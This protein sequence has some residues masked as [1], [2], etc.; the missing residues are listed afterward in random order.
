MGLGEAD[1]DD[2]AK[3]G[4]TDTVVSAD[5]LADHAPIVAASPAAT[6]HVGQN[7]PRSATADPHFPQKVGTFLSCSLYLDQHEASPG[8]AEP[9]EVEALG[10][11]HGEKLAYPGSRVKETNP[12]LLIN[13]YVLFYQSLTAVSKWVST[14]T[15]RMW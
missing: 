11:R 2:L 7:R 1:E 12:K 4:D 6:P 9:P 15:N 5:V 13:G 10:H 8:R 14:R 3:A